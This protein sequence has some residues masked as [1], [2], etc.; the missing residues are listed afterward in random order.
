MMEN[1]IIFVDTL[2]STN[3][4]MKSTQTAFPHACALA[5]RCQTAGRGQRGNSWEAAPGLNVTMSVMLR[6]DRPIPAASQFLV[7][8]AVSVAI[9]DVLRRYLGDDS[10]V[11]VKWPN[12]IYVTDRK[13]CG[14]LIEN[15]LSGAMLAHS[16]A[17]IGLNVNQDLFESP[18]PNPVSMLQVAGT[19]F[20]VA[21]VTEAVR[22]AIER[23]YPLCIDAPDELHR[24]YRA[25]LWR[26]HGLH[27]Y[28]DTATGSPFMAAIEDVEPS[29]HIILRTADGTLRRY[30]FKEM[31]AQLS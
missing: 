14:I 27:P 31:Q 9:V 24:R 15:S 18:A 25:M 6:H 22:A 8:E 7:S 12:D 30:A 13:I 21:E 29:G 2:D 26:R 19:R 23:L 5:C 16:V 17:G 28:V 11:S 4:R 20:D 3:A 1:R 10:H